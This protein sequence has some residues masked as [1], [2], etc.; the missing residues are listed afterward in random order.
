MRI[1][2]H[3]SAP[4]HKEVQTLKQWTTR[5]Y[6]CIA[7]DSLARHLDGVV[8]DELGSS[9]PVEK[10]IGYCFTD[11]GLHQYQ[12][13]RPDLRRLHSNY[14]DNCGVFA[15]VLPT[16][17][18]TA[19]VF[20]DPI[21]QCPIFYY[22]DQHGFAVSNS[23]WW[24]ARLPG[25]TVNEDCF[26]DF[27]VYEGPLRNETIISQIL[28]LKAGQTISLGESNNQPVCRIDYQRVPADHW[29]SM[30]YREL[31]DAAIT[32]IKQRAAAVL[33]VGTPLAHLSG[34]V[35]SRLSFSA[36]ASQGFRGPVFS[37]GWG[38]RD[39]RTIFE[40]L[41][42]RFG[43][44]VGPAQRD[45]PR[46]GLRD[47]LFGNLIAFNAQKTNN[48]AN[49]YAGSNLGHI[50]TN[51]FYSEGLVK[52]PLNNFMSLDG[53]IITFGWA[54]SKSIFPPEIFD[55]VHS[56]IADEVRPMMDAWDNNDV[57]V[58]QLH[59]MNTE[60]LHHF[61]TQ[62]MV[63]N[64]S[65]IS[66]DLL[67]D[68]MLM[69]LYQATPYPRR[70]RWE[71]ALLQDMTKAL[72]NADLAYFRCEDRVIEPYSKATRHAAA[73][74]WNSCF[75]PHKPRLGPDLPS[76][77]TVPQGDP[78]PALHRW[79]PVP[80]EDLKHLSWAGFCALP[81]FDDFF[82]RY[83]RFAAGRR[84][85]GSLHRHGEVISLASLIGSVY[86]VESNAAQQLVLDMP[87]GQWATGTV[88]PQPQQTQ[89]GQH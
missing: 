9:Q 22:I 70:A 67:Y 73:Q 35:D 55:H 58:E 76:L 66:P 47:A 6:F 3:L 2:C 87:S 31:F 21:A 5:D 41:V 30:S 51:G 61:G 17:T 14:V 48:W 59:C 77:P 85:E 74:R 60:C 75:T 26:D 81:I 39:D 57:F 79:L 24:L 46:S 29:W 88:S 69:V 82:A 4:P 40:G 33:E 89:G 78:R 62:S 7:S 56:R 80:A 45:H 54:Q 38:K 68:P 27:P 86:L 13:S 42:E 50:E 37:L 84:P 25:L 11:S 72:F 10:F 71:G 20:T 28:R 19:T 43:L 64:Q 44:S 65:Y 32:R 53:Q 83:P 15:A 12:L 36:L 8:P 23:F 18:D 16:G 63:N 34:G 52:P 49:A 1:T